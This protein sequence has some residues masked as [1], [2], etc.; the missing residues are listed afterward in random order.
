VDKTQFSLMI[1]GGALLFMLA[2]FGLSVKLYK[3]REF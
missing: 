3:G 2:S 1:I